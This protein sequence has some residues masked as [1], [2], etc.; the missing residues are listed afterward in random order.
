[1]FRLLA[2]IAG[3]LVLAAGF[4]ALVIDGTRSIAGHEI[5]LTPF[6]DLLRTRLPALQQAIVQNIHPLLW[7]PVTTGLLRLPVW[8]VLAAAGGLLLWVARRRAPAIGYS[9]RP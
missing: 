1:M 7:D 8:L 3:F 6:G 4:A 5:I 2:R 9:S